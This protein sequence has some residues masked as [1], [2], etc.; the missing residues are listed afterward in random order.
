MISRIPNPEAMMNLL[1]KTAFFLAVSCAWFVHGGSLATAGTAEPPM[2]TA[3]CPF[4]A[5]IA[6]GVE[7]YG[8]IDTSGK[9][10]VPPKYDYFYGFD[11]QGMGRFYV[12]GA[13]MG[14]VDAEGN[15][16][17]PP[18]LLAVSPFG[19][20]GRAVFINSDGDYGIIDKNGEIA[21]TTFQYLSSFNHDRAIFK[22]NDRFGFVNGSGDTAI[23]NFYFHVSPFDDAGLAVVGFE[24]DNNMLVD[25]EGRDVTSNR[26]EWIYGFWDGME[27]SPFRRGG[28]WGYLDR[29][30]REAIEPRFEFVGCF[31]ANGQVNE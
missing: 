26:Y 4:A 22:S 5:D 7:K 21:Q 6:P 14:F 19:D 27:L 15:E 16:V 23:H 13:G 8:L 18:G 20:N 17:I 30:G 9:V 24:L 10:V 12:E 25:T 11:K 28:K 1:M 31:G 3:L 29:E 2:P